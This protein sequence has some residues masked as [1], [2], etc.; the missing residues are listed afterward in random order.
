MYF[1]LVRFAF[2]NDGASRAQAMAND[3][4]PAIK[5]QPGLSQRR[6]FRRRGRW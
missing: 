1:R 4:V 6:P 5:A 2:A 3:L